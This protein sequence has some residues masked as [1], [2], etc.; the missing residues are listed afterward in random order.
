MIPSCPQVP[1]HLSQPAAS[2]PHVYTAIA[3]VMAA[4]ATAGISKSRTNEQQGFAFRGI[5][6]VYNSLAAKLV[7]AQLC[8]IPR[9]VARTVI[10]RT[11]ANGTALF[12]VVVDVEFDLV[13]ALDGSKHTARVCGEAMDTGD[14]ASSKALSAAYKYLAL[15][16][17]CIPTRGDND[18][19]ATTHSSILPTTAAASSPPAPA[20][21]D[22][23]STQAR[24][25]QPGSA[26]VARTPK[27]APL[28]MVLTRVGLASSETLRDIH[29]R[30][31]DNFAGDD[32]DRL[33]AAVAK[34]AKQLGVELNAPAA[35]AKAA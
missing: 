32:L 30:A 26:A 16:T 29:D 19:D 20:A 8:V 27:R 5:D 35:I 23:G 10:E 15:Q 13:S 18:A 1:P 6:D 17:F 7:A 21:F 4:M 12:A 11:T 2:A 34:R 33:R 14:K 28:D 24:D 9:V 22:L 25:A 31:A 3:Q